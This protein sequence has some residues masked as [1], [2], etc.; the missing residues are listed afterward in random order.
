MFLRLC[1]CAVAAARQT[2]DAHRVVE[3]VE[4]VAALR[5]QARTAAVL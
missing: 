3:V 2:G 5:A 1:S 4:E